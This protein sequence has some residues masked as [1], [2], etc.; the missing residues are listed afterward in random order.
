VLHGVVELAQEAL[1]APRPE[2]AH[3]GGGDLVADRVAEHGLV[4]RAGSRSGRDAAPNAA[5][6]LH[7]V[8]ERDVLLPRQVD[9]DAQVVPFGGIEKPTGRHAVHA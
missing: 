5:R 3:D 9:H 2:P 4:T 8:Q 6:Q 1:D 7:I